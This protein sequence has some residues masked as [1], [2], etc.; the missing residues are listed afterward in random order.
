MYA[1]LGGYTDAK[2]FYDYLLNRISVKFCPK[3]I[4]KDAE[5]DSFEIILNKKMSYDQ[6]STK[7][8]EHLK[9]DPTHIRFSTVNSTN[10]KPKVIVKRNNN[11]TLQQILAPPYSAYG[12]NTQS[13]NA[14]FYEVLDLSLSELETK[15]HLKVTWVSEGVTKEVI[16][17]RSKD[18]YIKNTLTDCVIGDLRHP[19]GQERQYVRCVTF[20]A[21]ESQP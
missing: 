13:S 16:T 8:G 20:I 14:L 10:G 12:S 4:A 7:V 18:P 11:Q 1:G 17:S 21:E 6:F 19:C 3:V 5:D 2:D 15:K 9:V